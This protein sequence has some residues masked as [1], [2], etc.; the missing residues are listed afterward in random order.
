MELEQEQIILVPNLDCLYELQNPQ[1]EDRVENNN[2]DIGDIKDIKNNQNNSTKKTIE[3]ILN[4]YETRRMLNTVAFKYTYVDTDVDN[5]KD[6]N[7]QTDKEDNTNDTEDKEYK[8]DNTNGTEDKED[9][10]SDTE[11]KTIE[12]SLQE[13]DEYVIGIDLGTTNTCVGIWRNENL[14][15]IPDEYGNRTIPSFVAF[16]NVNRYIGLDAKKQKDLNPQNVFYEIKRYIGR[17]I[18]DPLVVKESGLFSYKLSS[19]EHGN[20]LLVPDIVTKVSFT[21]EELSAA[22]LTKAKIMASNYLKENITKC[23]ITIPAYFND[24]QRQATKDAATIAGLDCIRI[25]NEPTAA[26]LAYGLLKRSKVKDDNSKTIMVYDFGGG[27]LDVS[28]LLIDDGIFK[29]IASCG[30]TR[31]G[32]SDFDNRIMSYCM[33]KFK[34]KYGIEELTEV[35][36]LGLQKLRS[37]CEQAKKILSTAIKTQIAVKNFYDGKDLY[38]PIT[39]SDFEKACREFFMICLKPIDDAL[40]VC[41][42]DIDEIDEIIMVGGMT[43]MP[44]IRELIKC[45][46]GREPNC[47][48]NPDEAIAAGA[49][50][51][52]FILSHF[53]DPFST[54][55]QLLD[56]VSLAIG[57]ETTGGVMD[58]II[59]RGDVIPTDGR[60]S[61]STDKDYMDSINVKIYE[62]ERKL[63][64]D[65]FLIGEFELEGIEKELRGIPEIDVKV[66]IDENGIIT[67]TAINMK[68]ADE[69]CLTVTSHKGRLTKMQIETLVAEAKELEIR[70]QLDKRKK[71]MH[72]QLDD[73]CH[74]ILDN[75]GNS[76][77]KLSQRDKV[78]INDD[79]QR[80]L[81][82]LAD[83]K[84]FERSDKEYEEMT[85]SIKKQYGVLI[86]TGH[87]EN[88]TIKD[89]SSGEKDSTTIYGGECDDEEEIKK[90]FEQIEDDENG[91][92]GMSDTDVSE[93]KELRQAVFDVC[94][95]VCEIVFSGSLA[96]AK[97]HSEQLKHYIDDTLLW[98]HIHEKPTKIE[99]KIK[100]DEINETC[101]KVFNYY[102]ETNE[103]IFKQNEILKA[104]KTSRDE[105]EN[106]CIVFELLIKDG[107]FPIDE[108]Y[109]GKFKE[110]IIGILK[111]MTEQ[112]EIINLDEDSEEKSTY[113]EECE[114]KINNLHEYSE[115]LNQKL[116]GINIDDKRD[117]LGRNRIVLTGMSTYMPAGTDEDTGIDIITLRQQEQQQ[118]MEDLI[119]ADND[120]DIDIEDIIFEEDLDN[121]TLS[122][123][124][125]EFQY[126]YQTNSIDNITNII[127]TVKLNKTKKLKHKRIKISNAEKRKRRAKCKARRI[128]RKR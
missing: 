29:V 73:F 107:A 36:S 98:L 15:I 1:T 95:S 104:N 126:T 47:S 10:T 27:T 24:G 49:A 85:K 118:V 17:K 37:A 32:G 23:V 25:I 101:N 57:V 3:M 5:R 58:S 87:L 124:K 121:Q 94:N 89:Y 88:T 97:D 91:F 43:R 14:E 111:W 82:W 93:L 123:Y 79:V 45:R 112:E 30:N 28:V 86:L 69:T 20:I 67:V 38:V 7:L 75:L 119:N 13:L 6:L 70:D 84:Y 31:M 80:V 71:L 50:I 81:Q 63:V 11:E 99:Y 46:F 90:T 39:R 12:C 74:N 51:Q 42:K 52:A 83:C 9:N 61:Y 105:L 110:K 72:Y 16:T 22:I 26:A 115:N 78:I 60:K 18:D 122:E 33:G 68:T 64:K 35:N 96:I 120:D 125:N 77:F 2:K 48:I 108:P 92:T 55:V 44:K 54:S 128:N 113:Y 19:D 114:L 21:P 117:I 41:E 65:N 53:S 66:T 59:E 100:I 106:M 56:T 40:K 127:S 4:E 103:D 102:T 8:E 109:L 34:R 76:Q 62:G 116:H